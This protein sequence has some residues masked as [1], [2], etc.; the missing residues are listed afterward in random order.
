M[1]TTR[2]TLTALLLCLATFSS[3]MAFEYIGYEGRDAMQPA[4]AGGEKKNVD[5]IDFWMSGTP[6]KPYQVLGSI[7]DE[8]PTN[9]GIFGLL[10]NLNRSVVNQVK[11]VGGDTVVLAVAQDKVVGTTGGGYVSGMN[12]SYGYCS[13]GYVNGNSTIDTDRITKYWV[14][15]YLPD[16]PGSAAG[17]DLAAL[18]ASISSSQNETAACQAKVRGSAEYA[19]V[20]TRFP[21]YGQETAQQLNDTSLPTDDEIAALKV[22]I[23]QFET[24]NIVYG[25]VLKKAMPAS[26][27]VFASFDQQTETLDADLMAKKISWGDYYRRNKAAHDAF[28]AGMGPIIQQAGLQ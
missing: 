4:G 20:S 15:K 18:K 9:K 24:C 7:T 6:T 2:L 26:L 16:A 13:G 17:E 19:S 28:F 12:C 23:P 8:R 5:G 10:F 3:A 1:K 21:G 11:K 22:V 14:V 25:N 27:M